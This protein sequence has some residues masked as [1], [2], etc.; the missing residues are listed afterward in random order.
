MEDKLSITQWL[1][2]KLNH[3]KISRL[4][5][6]KTMAIDL[7]NH[8]HFGEVIIIRQI[9]RQWFL[10]TWII[11]PNILPKVFHQVRAEAMHKYVLRISYYI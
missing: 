10:D 7:K 4:N 2:F 8:N 11:D 5:L 6:L 3:E 1:A 9:P